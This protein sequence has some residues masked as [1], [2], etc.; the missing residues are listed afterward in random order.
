M[1]T[2]KEYLATSKELARRQYLEALQSDV[3]A[4]LPYWEEFPINNRGSFPQ[5]LDE[6]RVRL[7][8]N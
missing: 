8:P 1:T 2:D 3:Q 7:C 6:A 5:T 4:D